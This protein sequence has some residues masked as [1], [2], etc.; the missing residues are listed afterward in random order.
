MELELKEILRS[1]FPTCVVDPIAKGELGADLVQ[2]VNGG[3]G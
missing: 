3:I 1:R 2:H